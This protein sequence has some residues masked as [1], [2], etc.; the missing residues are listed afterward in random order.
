[1][2]RIR[3]MAM[4]VLM[5]AM[6]CLCAAAEA[7]AAASQAQNLTGETIIQPEPIALSMDALAGKT[8]MVRVGAYHQE[9]HTLELTV[10]EKLRFAAEAVEG[11]QPGDALNLGGELLVVRQ[12]EPMTYLLL[13]DDGSGV[14]EASV[15]LKKGEDGDYEAGQYSDFIWR[16]VGSAPFAVAQDAQFLDGIDPEDGDMLESPTRHSMEEFL[17]IKEEEEERGYPGFGC[18][19]VWAAFNA[20]GEIASL[21][22]FY[23]PWQ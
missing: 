14:D 13:L 19:N 5:A 6:L 21:E 18:D 17:R 23:V 4:L 2:K 15:W 9:D 22:R 10:L 7:L 1:M 3:K 20:E 12:I 8:V 11:L 16:Q